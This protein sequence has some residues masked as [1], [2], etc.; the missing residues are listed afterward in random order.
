MNET[1]EFLAAFVAPAPRGAQIELRLHQVLTAP[2]AILTR[3][4][5]ELFDGEAP[6]LAANAATRL[7]A[8]GTREVRAAMKT[9]GGTTTALAWVI[10]AKRSTADTFYARVKAAETKYN[11]A[12]S[13]VIESIDGLVCIVILREPATEVD[14]KRLAPAATLFANALGASVPAVPPRDL[15]LPGM[16]E[17][18]CGKAPHTVKIIT[19]SDWRPTVDELVHLSAGGHGTAGTAANGTLRS[20]LESE[21][22]CLR[23]V[24][25][26]LAEAKKSNGA[27][28]L[29]GAPLGVGKTRAALKTLVEEYSSGAFFSL[30]HAQLDERENEASALGMQND[31][32]S[33]MRGLLAVLNDDGSRACAYAAALEP[34]G[35]RGFQLRDT[36][37]VTCELRRDCKA[38]NSMA[39]DSG[40]LFAPHAAFS[41]LRKSGR[42]KSPIVIDELP[43]PFE[44]VRLG[45]SDAVLIANADTMLKDD[46]AAAWCKPRKALAEIVAKTLAIV[47][48]KAMRFA[49]PDEKSEATD[50]ELLI[51]GERARHAIL[52]GAAEAA[53]HGQQNAFGDGTL[54]AGREALISASR[55]F[56]PAHDAAPRMPAPDGE[57]IRRGTALAETWPAATCDTVLR[58]FCILG[59]ASPEQTTDMVRTTRTNGSLAIVAVV[60]DG[61]TTVEITTTRSGIEAMLD[62]IDPPK[63]MTKAKAKENAMY[64]ENNVQAAGQTSK[65]K[66]RGAKR[67]SVVIL[68][69]TASTAR[70]LIEALCPGRK[71]R[72]YEV[73]KPTEHFLKRMWVETTMLSRNRTMPHGFITWAG[74]GAWAEAL[75]RVAEICAEH[76]DAAKGGVGLIGAKAATKLLQ[77]IIETREAWAPTGNDETGHA[78]ALKN[79]TLRLAKMT[80]VTM[81]HWGA[82]RGSN[83]MEHVGLIALVGD[84]FPNLSEVRRQAIAVGMTI[85]DLMK[86]YLDV[87]VEQGFGRA[88]AIRRAD[89]PPIGVYFGRTTP[90]CWDGEEVEHGKLS[91]VAPTRAD[92]LRRVA[93]LS[94]ETLGF[95][96]IDVCKVAYAVAAVTL[97]PSGEGGK[98]DATMRRMEAEIRRLFNEWESAAR[99]GGLPDALDET[100]RSR[101]SKKAGGPQGRGGEEIREA[102]LE[103][104]AKHGAREDLL[105]WARW[106]LGGGAVKVWGETTAAR[107]FLDWWLGLGRELFADGLYPPVGRNPD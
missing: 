100:N 77:E 81:L 76:Q 69:A 106:G 31:K 54:I 59:L 53:G 83:L 32:K 29:V 12:F 42:L 6:H 62:E 64:Q 39:P 10:T 84:P 73:P 34:W 45:A 19:R 46:R 25:T 105:P 24:R 58:D 90:A 11:F 16:T 51:F 91:G 104:T 87:E 49:K 26:A 96:S 33:R 37:C 40:I 50:G 65:R 22:E 2:S 82:H 70:P 14:L 99:G 57:L 75:N 20:L 52:C 89:N 79:A 93:R 15:P 74:M 1:E 30:S 85:D 101:V 41:P 13:F 23:I 80:T 66:P 17:R 92:L 36:A 48:T 21:T 18:R 5:S 3:P 63:I 9:P 86:I 7:E 71:L 102:I 44:T 27:V 97:S 28:S 78:I 61:K 107:G 4:R 8:T 88:R 35:G 98:N 72:F 55:E 68:D 103:V 94:L 47:A 38:F 43:A 60:K 67:P 56:Y 95:V